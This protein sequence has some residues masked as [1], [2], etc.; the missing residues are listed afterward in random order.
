MSDTK[1]YKAVEAFADALST[2]ADQIRNANQSVEDRVTAIK[3]VL[4]TSGLL[5]QEDAD[6]LVNR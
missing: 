6:R 4:E 1:S 2:V 3:L 5:T